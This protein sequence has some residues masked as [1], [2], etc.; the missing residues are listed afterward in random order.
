MLA[1]ELNPDSVK[2]VREL[3]VAKDPPEEQTCRTEEDYI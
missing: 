2:G 1:R 3:T